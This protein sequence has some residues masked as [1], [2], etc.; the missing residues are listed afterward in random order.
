MCSA[1]EILLHLAR[2]Y[3]QNLLRYASIVGFAS[4]NGAFAVFPINLYGFKWMFS[5]Y[6]SKNLEVFLLNRFRI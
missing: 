5:I 4:D 6:F 1:C 3:A 2:I